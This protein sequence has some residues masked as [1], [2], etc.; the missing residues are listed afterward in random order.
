SAMMIKIGTG[1][2]SMRETR[3]VKPIPNVV[4]WSNKLSVMETMALLEL[5]SA[6][7]GIDSGPLHLAGVLGVP[8]VGLFGPIDGKLR[9]HPR[10]Q[11]K[12][13][14]GNTSCLGCHHGLTGRLHWRTG[15]PY[16]IECMQGIW[17][18]TVSRTLI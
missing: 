11:T 9:L 2:D 14:T 10:A 4:D 16:N 5:S 17:A 12:I 13:V 3:P 7:V 18:D 6:F 15:C 8:S 1:I